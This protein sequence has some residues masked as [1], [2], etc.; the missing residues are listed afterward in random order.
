[1]KRSIH[2]TI[3]KENLDIDQHDMNPNIIALF[4]LLLN[5][6]GISSASIPKKHSPPKRHKV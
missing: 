2:I 1:V 4:S 5:W 6:S 3:L